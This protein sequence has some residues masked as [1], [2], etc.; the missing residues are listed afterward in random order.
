MA[1]EIIADYVRRY[2]PAILEYCQ[3]HPDE[4][5]RLMDGNHCKDVFKLPRRWP[6]C[7]ESSAVPER[8]HNKYWVR[9]YVHDGMTLR[10]CSQ[11][12]ERLHRESFTRYL[13]SKGLLDSPPPPPPPLPPSPDRANRYKAR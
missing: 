11:W 5:A 13:H 2:L 3:S 12:V 4:L 1:Q 10:V 8:E 6:F 9:L 7:L